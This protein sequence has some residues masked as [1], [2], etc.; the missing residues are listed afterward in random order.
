MPGKS[1]PDQV[2]F[3]VFI[4]GEDDRVDDGDKEIGEAHDHINTDEISAEPT[5]ELLHTSSSV[6][7]R[8]I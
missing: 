8:E 2:R 6:P 3:N 5:R 4:K 7:A 1:T